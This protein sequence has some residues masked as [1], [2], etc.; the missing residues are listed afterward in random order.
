LGSSGKKLEDVA[1]HLTW[2]EKYDKLNKANKAFVRQWQIDK[3]REH[4]TM[5]Q[6]AAQNHRAQIE[7]QKS[8]QEMIRAKREEEKERERFRL[9]TWK[10]ML[11]R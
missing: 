10:V 1:K 7:G 8:R 5:Y 2:F 4:E 11:A 3:R 9:E 6:M